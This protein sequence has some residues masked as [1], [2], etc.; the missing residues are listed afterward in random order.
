MPEV[1]VIQIESPLWRV[2]N[3]R[4]AR[5]VNPA[6]DEDF[7]AALAEVERAPQPRWT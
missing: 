6:V 2:A 4:P 7:K 1:R 3:A 5:A